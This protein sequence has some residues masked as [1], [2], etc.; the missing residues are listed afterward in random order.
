MIFSGIEH[1]GKVPFHHVNIHGLILDGQGRKMSKSL[2]NGID[3]IEVIEKYGAD[4]LR[5]SMITG[6]TPG[7]DIRFNWDKVENT[8]NFANKIWNASRFVLMNMEGY[9]PIKVNEDEFTLADR[10]ILSRL[11]NKIEEM[12]AMLDRYDLGEAA[13]T[14]YDFIWDEF[15]DWYI[16]LAKPRLFRPENE[17]QRLVVQNVLKDVL[18]EILTLLHPFMP[19]ITE[20]IYHYLPG[21]DETI[22][23]KDWPV[24]DESKLLPEAVDQMQEIMGAIRAIRNIRAEFNVSPGSKVKAIIVVS[25]QSKIEFLQDN[26]SYIKDMANVDDLQVLAALKEKPRQAVSAL[27]SLAE[28]YIPLEGIIDVAKEIARLEKELKNV[29]AD[30]AKSQAKLGNEKFLAKAPQEVVDKEKSRIEESQFKKEGILQRLQIL[31]S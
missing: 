14:M 16:E 1:T 28:I 30:M 25:E 19:F 17:R 3:P 22:M 13:R 26:G 21:H 12:T 5:F 2:G 18:T 20:E 29:Q 27:T 31:K 11:N 7:N 23:L 6:V 9:E 8:R 4:T 15:C 24:P 10:W